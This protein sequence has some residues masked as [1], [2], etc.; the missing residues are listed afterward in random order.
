MIPAA[1][2]ALAALALAACGDD[3]AGPQPLVADPAVTVGCAPGPVGRARAK[4]VAC[5]EE[6]I[7]G[8]LAAGRIGDV[9]LENDRVR[10]IIRAAGEGHYLHGSRG[11]G[12]VDAA[13][14][15]GEDLVKEILPIVDLAAGG[16]DELVIVEAGNDGPAEVVVRGPA[17]GLDLIRSA[18]SREAPPLIVEH[19]YR[20][21]TGADAVE[22]DTRIYDAPGADPEPGPHDLYDAMFVGGRAQ[23]FVPGHG[24]I[25]GQIAGELFATAGTSTSYGLVYPAGVPEIQLIDLA[26]IRLALGPSI[27]IGKPVTRW[28][29]LGDGSVASVT[30][31]AWTLHGDALGV[32]TG[33]TSP[34]ADVTVLAGEA[35]ITVARA[36]A[37]GAFRIA[38]PPGAYTLQ[39]RVRGGEAGAAVAVDVSA[40][41]TEAVVPAGPHATLALAVRDD[42]SAA[43]PARVVLDRAGD[44]RRIEWVGAT[45]DTRITVAPGTWRVAVS[46]GL[47]YEAFVASAL[48]I[49]D[50]QTVPLAVTL[51]RVID[52]AGWISLDTHLH[53]ELSTD[54]TFPIDDRL[55]AVAAEGVEVPVSSDHDF[56]VD[57][58]P[59]IDELG[60]GAWLGSL[61]G[62][63]TSSLIWGHAN[64]WPLAADAAKA[65]AGSPP[66]HGRSPG[67][68]FAALRGDGSAIVQ[69]N[70]PRYGTS[71]LFD[72]IDL[73]PTTLV[74]REDPRQLGLPAGTDLSDLGFDAIEVANALGD[75]DFDQVF[76]DYLAMVA[77][78]HPAVATGSSDSHG[79][80]AFAGE[81]RTYV[82]VGAGADDPAA[83]DPAAIVDGLH[84]RHSIVATCAFATAGIET[85]GGTSLPG[86]TVDVTNMAQVSLRVRVQAAPW[87][88]LAR[89]RIFQGRQEVRVIALDPQDTAVVRYDAAVTLPTPT[90]STFWVVRVEPAG[91]GDPVLD[92]PMPTFT[93]PVFGLVQ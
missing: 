17:S 57:Y 59:I 6:L 92:A 71:S 66:W 77:A 58:A 72:A 4:L 39:A 13:V 70:H 64:A 27:E 14:A 22:L 75:E 38:V 16:S 25:D 62:T 93:N 82:W 84:A 74:A 28:L 23:G 20:L 12:I 1:R 80:S 61:T 11:G 42:N 85:T 24:F 88:P 63:E 87:Q 33:T 60:L 69:V 83:V 47:E 78:G 45:G 3:A 46:R 2:V 31:R 65:G 91:P 32:V 68:V 90:A 10:V 54:S 67:E 81:A 36:D 50:G 37:A 86:D 49:A 21:A 51:A 18:L 15:G 52:T 53:S 48:A 44:A 43:L 5:S 73:D 26:G 35:A 34:D 79:P 76:G 8:R 30:E 41:A 56:I 19:H 89:I 9:L 40:A 29:V 7:G 55:R